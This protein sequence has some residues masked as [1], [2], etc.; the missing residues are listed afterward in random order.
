MAMR[1]VL[2]QGEAHGLG[3]YKTYPSKLE[4]LA[5]TKG[6][7]YNIDE[8]FLGKNLLNV[9]D[10]LGRVHKQIARHALESKKGHPDG[11]RALQYYRLSSHSGNSIRSY[12]QVLMADLKR[13]WPRHISVDHKRP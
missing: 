5:Q 2:C 9:L 10:G 4:F 11:P 1:R 8:S 7:T 6:Y 13:M 3:H 12:R